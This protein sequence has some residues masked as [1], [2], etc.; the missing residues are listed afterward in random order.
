LVHFF[1]DVLLFVLAFAAQ[2]HMAQKLLGAPALHGSAVRARTVRVLLLGG[3]VLLAAGYLLGFTEIRS[4]LPITSPAVGIFSGAAEL[5]LLTTSCG[6]GL[7]LLFRLATRRV[8]PFNASR[9]RVLN[10]AGGVLL[11]S[12][13]FVVGYGALIERTR[14]GVREVDIEIPGLH[15]DLEGLRILQLTDI[16]LSPFL[17]ARELQ[18]VIHAA[19]ETNPHLALV[20]GDL[21]SSRGDPLDD[22]LRLVATVKTDAGIF[23][24]LGNHEHY[25][26][27]E[28][29]AAEEGARMGIRFLRGQNTPLQFGGAAMNLAGVDYERMSASHTG[30]LRGAER[31]VVPGALNVLMSHNPDVF[32]TAAA[33][34]YDLTVAGHTHGG[35]VNIEILSRD[36][37]PAQFFTEYVY[38]RYQ[39]TGAGRKASAYVSRGI[40]TIGIPARVGAPPEIAVLRLRK[41]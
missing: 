20:T 11:A 8:A 25:S 4:Y 18:R 30:Y 28:T 37:N 33:Q 31:M 38:G 13:F 39:W 26:G 27:V 29:H 15:P 19:N 23:G 1:L 36:I 16:H 12:P 7:Y 35:Q 24:C 34:G 10:T 3:T 40:G 22:C 5:W 6:Y 14:F 32:P 41:A 17:S 21:I 9:R 2:W